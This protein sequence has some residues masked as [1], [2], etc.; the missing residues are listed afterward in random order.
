MADETAFQL[1]EYVSKIPGIEGSLGSG[2]FDDG[3]WWVKFTINIQHELAW[4]VVQEL[5]RRP[6]GRSTGGGVFHTKANLGRYPVESVNFLTS[7][8]AQQK[9]GVVRS[10]PEPKAK[11]TAHPRIR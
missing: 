4:R 8:I 9:R 6:G 3:R 2:I 10:Q 1:T 5:G 11:V 7:G